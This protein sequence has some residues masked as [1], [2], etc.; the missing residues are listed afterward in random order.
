MLLFSV[1]YLFVTLLCNNHVQI[2][3]MSN[4]N[5]TKQLVNLA[6]NKGLIRPL[7]LDALEIPRITLTRLV[8]KGIFEKVSRGV[9]R[10]ANQHYSEYS[11]LMTVAVK[12]PQ[13]VFCLLT[14]LQF[15]ELTTQLPRD[16]WIAMPKGRH[17][18]RLDY[19]P[20][21]MIQYSNNVF[22]S[23]INTYQHNGVTLRVYSIEKTI[24][25]C[26]KHRNKIGIDVAI[27][28]LKEAKQKQLLSVDCLWQFAKLCRVT[29]II[30][31]YLESIE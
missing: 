24:A 25:D 7:D 18:P 8:E 15:H 22:H 20:L 16:I 10:V 21:K 30:R 4:A 28:A 3:F 19:P 11:D 1:T 31:P 13:A 9:Y 5:R 27:E 26:F 14:A 29:N 23:G 6:K 2:Y 17:A 12:A